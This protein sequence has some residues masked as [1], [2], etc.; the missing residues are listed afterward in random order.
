MEYSYD[1]LIQEYETIQDE[2]EQCK[3]LIDTHYKQIKRLKREQIGYEIKR[4]ELLQTIE[5][6]RHN[7]YV[8]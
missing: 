6:I 5:L 8:T 1:V 4:R 7:D 3:F 2:I